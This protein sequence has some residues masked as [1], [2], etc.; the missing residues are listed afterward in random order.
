MLKTV[1]FLKQ[2]KKKTFGNQIKALS[3]LRAKRRLHV[4][5]MGIAKRRKWLSQNSKNRNYLSYSMKVK[6]TNVL[7]LLKLSSI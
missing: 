6:K 5:W 7:Y 3:R 1:S 2:K 4:H